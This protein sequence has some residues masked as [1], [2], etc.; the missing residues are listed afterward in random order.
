M[1]PCHYGYLMKKYK[2]IAITSAH[3]MMGRRSPRMSARCS[4]GKKRLSLFQI[5]PFSSDSDLGF[6]NRLTTAQTAMQIQNTT[7]VR[8][9]KGIL[10]NADSKRSDSG[11]VSSPAVR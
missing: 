1:R 6:V 5:N 4:G 3:Q 11:T 8:F 7:P 10:G 2:T 9:K